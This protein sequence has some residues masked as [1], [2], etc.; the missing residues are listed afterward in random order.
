MNRKDINRKWLKYSLVLATFC[1][2]MTIVSISFC[3]TLGQSVAVPTKQFVAPSAEQFN[4]QTAYA[5]VGK[6][7]E[8]NTTTD[9]AGNLLMPV[10]EY[11][12]TII[13]NVTKPT[14]Q[15]VKY[16]AILEVYSVS[17]AT[18]K[19]LVENFIYFIGT[20][21]NP[22]FSEQ[23]LDNLTAGIYNLFDVNK[24]DAV[25]GNFQFNWTGDE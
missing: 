11:P 15:E 13:F 24:V 21:T 6:G 14:A 25:R 19:G 22:S 4:L 9:N 12:S 3:I 7:A 16:D 10:S 17:V 8:N 20:N 18:D 23:E 2:I 1:I 5:Y